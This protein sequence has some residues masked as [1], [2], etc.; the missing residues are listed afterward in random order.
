M[1][2]TIYPGDYYDRLDQFSKK[3]FLGGHSVAPASNPAFSK[4]YHAIWQTPGLKPE[5]SNG[6]Q[7]MLK[8]RICADLVRYTNTERLLFYSTKYTLDKG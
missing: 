7:G 8:L 4:L 6:P 2:P 1:R 5:I 3:E